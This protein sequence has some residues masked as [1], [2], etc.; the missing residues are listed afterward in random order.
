MNDFSLV[1]YGK[2]QKVHKIDGKII[3]ALITR[4]D[5]I[6]KIQ[7]QWECKILGMPEKTSGVES[8]F[9]DA[10]IRSGFSCQDLYKKANVQVP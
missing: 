10:C 5:S 7:Y 9:Y 4:M 3:E 1:S 8:S 6:E 2:W